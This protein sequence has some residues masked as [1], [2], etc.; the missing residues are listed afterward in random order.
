VTAHESILLLR[1]LLFMPATNARAHEKAVGLPAD[2]IIFDLEDAVSAGQKDA[3]RTQL[4]SSLAAHTY[5]GKKL[6]LRINH[7]DTPESTADLA[8]FVRLQSH[9][10][11][12]VLPKVE[13]A[14]T[15]HNVAHWLDTQQVDS[16]KR[17]L[18]MIETPKAVLAL[19][20]IATAHPRLLALVAGTN[21]LAAALHLFSDGGRGGLHYCLSQIV[22]TARAHGLLTF[23]G[24]FNRLDDELGFAGECAEGRVLGFDGKTLIHPMQIELANSLFR[25]SA[26]EVEQAQAI[27]ASTV[28]EDGVTTAHGAMI[29]E[30]HLRHAQRILA[31]HNEAQ[32]S[33]LE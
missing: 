1:S 5:A 32:K 3:G 30:L 15:I 17:I 25:P 19:P 9:F 4:E 10:D 12:L 11:G 14:D 24:V 2:A 27:I 16:T 18:A 20:A 13:H 26:E 23:D 6:F 29:E 28:A 22:L 21:D 7:P 31:L 33:S 8:F